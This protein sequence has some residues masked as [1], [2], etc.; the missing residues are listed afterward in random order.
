MFSP[1]LADE[2]T[3]WLQ[4]CNANSKTINL[5]ES[6]RNRNQLSAKLGLVT[7][8]LILLS[9]LVLLLLLLYVKDFKYS[10]D[11]MVCKPAAIHVLMLVVLPAGVAAIITC[12]CFLIEN[13]SFPEHGNTL[14][15]IRRFIGGVGMVISVLIAMVMLSFG[16]S[17]LGKTNS[18]PRYQNVSGM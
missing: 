3:H 9:D 5:N 1:F 8:P 16:I 7:L 10:K 14:Q 18:S 13:S 2:E 15:K 11:V 6:S 4:L 12:F 17:T